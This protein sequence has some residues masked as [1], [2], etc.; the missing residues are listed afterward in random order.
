MADEKNDAAE[1]RQEK[2]GHLP[3]PVRV[4]DT[5]TSQE[6]RRPAAITTPQ[7][8]PDDGFAG[9]GKWG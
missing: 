5:V 2:Y 3:P 7:S 6:T 4:E 1:A 9:A 8:D